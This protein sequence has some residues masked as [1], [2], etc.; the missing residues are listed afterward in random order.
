MRLKLFCHRSCHA[1]S[2][3]G[4]ANA[5]NLAPTKKDVRGIYGFEMNQ[6]SRCSIHDMHE[7]QKQVEGRAKLPNNQTESPLSPGLQD[8]CLHN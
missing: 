5:V 3:A 7:L 4:Q 1:S 8:G 6:S 2:R